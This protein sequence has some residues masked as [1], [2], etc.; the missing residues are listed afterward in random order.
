MKRSIMLIAVAGL[1]SCGGGGSGGASTSPPDLASAPGETALVSYLQGTHQYTLSATDNSGNAFTLKLSSQPYPGT[2]TFN[3]EAPA[4]STVDT[5]TLNANGVLA[6]NSISTGY[7]LLNPYV[8]LGKTFSTGTPYAVVTSSTPF[9]ATLTVG[10][11]GPVDTLTYYHDSTMGI[12]DANEQG[13]YSVQAN[14]STTLLMCLNFTVS[15]VT[16][17]GAADGLAAD[18]ESDCYTV[19]ASGNVALV[20]IALTVNGETLNFK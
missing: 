19:D 14:N 4:Y 10:S 16:A 7:Y 17:Q 18:T 1:Y 2:T 8:P 6:A 11:S 9:P 12:V 3:G 5:L 15:D 20:S 13:T